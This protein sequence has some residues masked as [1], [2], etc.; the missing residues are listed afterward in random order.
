[1][2]PLGDLR[3]RCCRFAIPLFLSLILVLSCSPPVQ[4]PTGLA[5]DYADAKEMF[6]R[7]RLDR[8]I[9]I[10]EGVAE[11]TPPGKYVYEA[12]V[13]RAV[14][15]SG[16]VRAFKDLADSYGKG[17]KATHYADYAVA[18]RRHR[19]DALQMGG[20][21]ALGL[22]EVAQQFI[23]EG[24]LPKEL[25]LDAPWPEAEG[26]ESVAQL[27]QVRQGARVSSEDL[28]A[29][30]IDARRKG[31]DDALAAIVGGDRAKA[32]TALAAGP[33]KL[34]GVDF[35][36]FLDKELLNAARMFDNQHLQDPDKLK[37]LCSLADSVA[38]Q[39]LA[40]LKETPNMDQ[41][42][43]IKKVQTSIKK[44]MQTA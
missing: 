27:D 25:T 37:T 16:Q 23:A 2:N 26:P 20:N 30:S 40:R 22:G 21:D 34:D 4:R 11:T 38:Q 10:T 36:I 9:D 29:A 14:V 18:Y 15:F 44:M 39:A 41:E 12:R 32:R 24:S 19:Q 31:I 17:Q 13:L 6:K 5:A 8:V 35:A 42:K 1:M 3:P 28:D 7:G 43:E 33:V